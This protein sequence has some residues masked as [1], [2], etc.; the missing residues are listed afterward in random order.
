VGS[1]GCSKLEMAKLKLVIGEHV[2]IENHIQPV[3]A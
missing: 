3:N 2:T 1:K